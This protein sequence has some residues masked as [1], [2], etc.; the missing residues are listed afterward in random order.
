ME[1][2]YAC[3]V[4]HDH[5]TFV[6]ARNLPY[7]AHV[8]VLVVLSNLIKVNMAA[9]ISHFLFFLLVHGCTNITMVLRS[10]MGNA[11]SFALVSCPK[12]AVQVLVVLTLDHLDCLAGVAFHPLG[13]YL[14]TNSFDNPWRLG[15]TEAGEELLYQQ[16]FKPVKVLSDHESKVTYVDVAAAG[17]SLATIYASDNLRECGWAALA[18]V[19][20]YLSC[21]LSA[22]W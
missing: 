20:G 8:Q 21:L 14:G 18:I 12:K 13:K 3:N 19:L 6:K 2:G 22:R 17:Q 1:C 9:Q 10:V 11:V 15:N 7:D 4:Y 16:D 5:L